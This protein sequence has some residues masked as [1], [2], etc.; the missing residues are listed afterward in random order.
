[1]D[2]TSSMRGVNEKYTRNFSLNGRNNFGDPGVRQYSDFISL[3]LFFQN[4]ES[5]L[6]L[7]LKKRIWTGLIWLRIGSSVGSSTYIYFKDIWEG[8]LV[9]KSNDIRDEIQNQIRDTG[10]LGIL[11][12]HRPVF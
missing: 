2:G 9:T 3:L 10:L 11:D 12:F 8:F 6:K 4:K 7:I 5:T 1:M